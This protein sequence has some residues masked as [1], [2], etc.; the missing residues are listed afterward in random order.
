M[1][2]QKMP[3]KCQTVKWEKQKG[4]INIGHNSLTLMFTLH[5]RDNLIMDMTVDVYNAFHK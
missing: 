2:Q 3:R 5:K 1:G 4:Q